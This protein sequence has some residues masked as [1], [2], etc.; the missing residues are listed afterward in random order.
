MVSLPLLSKVHDVEP[1]PVAITDSSESFVLA[2]TAISPVEATKTSISSSRKR[3]IFSPGFCQK[4]STIV[5]D[6]AIVSF[7]LPKISRREPVS[8][9]KYP[10]PDINA[11]ACLPR[12]LF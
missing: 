11:S 2:P 3:F 5:A 1:L 4:S 7:V 10:S 12:A 6:G 9:L 8:T